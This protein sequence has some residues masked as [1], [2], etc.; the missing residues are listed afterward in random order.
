MI[1]WLL[2]ACATPDLA[3]P[4]AAPPPV[5]AAPDTPSP[6]TDCMALC[7][8]ANMARAVDHTVIQADCRRAC[9]Q[10]DKPVLE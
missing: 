8:R 7:T 6:A 10:G 2:F 4:P 1:A 5:L 3:A 9:E